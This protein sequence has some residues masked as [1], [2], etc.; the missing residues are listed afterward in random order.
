MKNLIL[1]TTLLLSL[2]EFARSDPKIDSVYYFLDINKTSVNDRMWQIQQEAGSTYKNY[3][4]Q[5]ACLRNEGKPTFYYSKEDKDSVIHISPQ[6]FKSIK[7]ISL[8]NLILKSKQ[9][10]NNDYKHDYAI[11]LIEPQ[12]KEYIMRAV[13]FMNPEIKITSGPDVVKIVPNNSAFKKDGLIRVNS[14]Y[15]AKYINK[16][17]I[18]SGKIICTK[19][20][21][22]DNMVLLAISND[23]INTDLNIIIKNDNRIKF[24]MPEFYY[25]GKLVEVTGK[26]IEYNNNPAIEITDP[27][28]ILVINK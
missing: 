8:S 20:I 2:N 27:N 24:D 16:S 12:G 22:S 6:K 23:Q 7:L 14:K 3:S 13:N 18:T 25:K 5:C 9:I 15:I 26:V 10:E 4:I 11:F 1:I 19:V 17:V 21:D 28:Q